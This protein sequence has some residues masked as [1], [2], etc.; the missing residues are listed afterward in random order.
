LIEGS[1]ARRIEA[2]LLIDPPV[3]RDR[4]VAILTGALALTASRSHGVLT[5]AEL[6]AAGITRRQIDSSL[7]LGELLAVHPGVYRVAAATRTWHQRVLEA[8]RA[9]GGGALASH[10]SAAALWGLD[11]STRGLPEIVTPRHLRSWAVDLGRRHES[12]DLQHAQPV[13]RDAIPCTGLARTLVDLGAVQPIERVQQAVDDAVRRRLCTWDDLLHALAVH[14]RQGRNGVGV[15][16]A[17]LEETYGTEIPDSHFNRL[18][19]RLLVAHG[20]PRPTVEHVVRDASGAE[21][22]RLDLAFVPHRVGVELDSRRYHLNAVAFEHD[23]HR[24][25][26]LELQG[27]MILRY[28]W[29]QY[30]RT[31][32]R[33][34]NEVAAALRQR[35]PTAP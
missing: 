25:N 21:I 31:A 10:R 7:A 14:S 32:L 9:G 15:L 5:R 2:F 29:L 6:L 11:G 18:V 30:T 28:T 3:E 12:K 22:G 8:V 33:I 35:P 23:R 13:D 16:R 17:I 1:N 20:L 26:R 19:E 24:Q 4:P 34:V 27:W